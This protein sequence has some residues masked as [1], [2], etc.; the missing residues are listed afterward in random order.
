MF[1]LL[2]SFF[3]LTTVSHAQKDS[4]RKVQNL[5]ELVVV[6]KRQPIKFG[7]QGVTYRVDGIAGASRNLYDVISSI[8]GVTI[9]ED[10]SVTINGKSGCS[11]LMDGKKIPISGKDLAAML[12][13]MSVTDADKIDVLS[14]P[15]AKYEAE[16]MGVIDIHS[17]KNKM[18]GLRVVAD[19]SG[20]IGRNGGGDGSLSIN[21]KTKRW[22]PYFTGSYSNYN[23]IAD[24]TTERAFKQERMS[25]NCL[26]KF[27]EVGY[28]FLAG[29]DFTPND[30]S[31]FNIY[32]RCLYEP[33]TYDARMNS[34]TSQ[35]RV[36]SESRGN[37]DTKPTNVLTGIGY[38]YHFSENGLWST[39]FDY[40]KFHSKQH[41]YVYSDTPDSTIG[42]MKNDIDIFLVHSDLT[43]PLSPA[44]NIE[45]GLKVST[46]NIHNDLK[47]SM[48][49]TDDTNFKYEEDNYATYLETN[50]EKDRWK[51]AAGL[52]LEY[53]HYNL[54]NED[55][56]LQA[57][58]VQKFNKAYLFPSASLS[59][60]I[61]KKQSLM[62]SY[63]KRIKR[64][65]YIEMNPFVYIYDKYTI[66]H[67]NTGLKPSFL[68]NIELSYLNLEIGQITGT[69][70]YTEDALVRDFAIED[71]KVST[72]EQNIG[73]YLS[74]GLRYQAM[75][76]FARKLR[77]M[78]YLNYTYNRYKWSDGDIKH[79]NSRFTP[80]IGLSS[81]YSLPSFMTAQLS[82]NYAGKSA[83]GRMTSY[84]FYKV[85]MSLQKK[86]CD[87]KGTITLFA[88]DIFD[89]QRQKMTMLLQDKEANYELLNHLRCL[90]VSFSW[91]FT[92]GIE[93]KAKKQDNTTD[94]VDR[95]K[96]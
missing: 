61:D 37:S 19:A 36:F 84:D 40:V 14:Q 45:C 44:W 82:A 83:Y 48:A 73:D 69:F 81:T 46:I 5:K 28:D 52:R 63:S 79:T 49:R 67:G 32:A 75:K 10:G 21:Y 92:K 88:N 95:M 74:A 60:T 77:V 29:C 72:F 15:S 53:T 22:N 1:L 71:E 24:M 96:M 66:R 54:D 68:H 20:R 8:P 12:R 27:N 18:L 86:I 39:S 38:K 33:E 94:E 7:T 16:G 3:L 90:G 59:Y 31:T 55:R 93:L 58:S 70:S 41:E 17:K 87:G 30:R 76:Y 25:Q 42:N 64:P 91:T 26:R 23:A 13:T 4:I 89:S 43:L 35:T 78:F 9:D 6:S 50:Y 2:M 56:I 51:F 85:N 65:N 11:I 47:Y 80:I 62:L 34:L 57:D